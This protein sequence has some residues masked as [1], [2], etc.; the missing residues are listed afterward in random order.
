MSTPKE[1]KWVR[2]GE[3]IQEALPGF[4][5]GKRAGSEGFIQLR[6]NNISGNGQLNLSSVLRV[7]ATKEQIERYR[8]IPGDVIFNNTNSAELVGKTTLFDEIDGI[9]LYSN[10]LTR[11]RPVFKV[12]DSSYLALWLQ[13]QWYLRI[14][15]RI[16]NRWIGQAAVQREKLL[17]LEIPLPCFSEQKRIAA[18]IQRLIHEV[19]RARTACEKQLDTVK[20]LPS[21]YLREVFES[22]EAKKWER[23][24]LGQIC[25]RIIGGGTPSRGHSEYWGDP[26]YWLSPSELKEN[27]INYIKKTKEKITEEGSRNSNA[28]LIPLK[29]VL[30]SCTASVGKV[31][32]NEVPLSTNQQ[33]NSFVLRDTI[34]IPEYIA[35]YLIYKRDNIKQLGGKTTFTFISKDEIANL[36]VF[37]PSLSIQHRIVVKLKEKMAQVEELRTGIEKQ[38]ESINAL[39]Q[40]ILRKAFKGEL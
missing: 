8:L 1:W 24:R 40:A 6:M 23:K 20:A 38:L 16:C 12:L 9:F 39:P 22:E 2:L 18:K 10:H 17:N 11:L 29:S 37:I 21:A 27:K 34:A 33:F 26:I 4:A 36:L 25:Y 14:F 15:E 3:V 32:I 13:L 28:K 31:A 5:C 19:E 7:P 30:L 35:Y